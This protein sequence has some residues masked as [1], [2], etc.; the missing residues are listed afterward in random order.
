MAES[1]RPLNTMDE[2]AYRELQRENEELKKKVREA[3][4]ETSIVKAVGMNS[5][6]MRRLKNENAELL[7]DNK[8]LA[9]QIE[10]RIDQLRKA[11]M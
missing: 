5:P 8:K 3:E 7:A 4:G 6:E 1:N 9:H 10:D 2:V 11:G